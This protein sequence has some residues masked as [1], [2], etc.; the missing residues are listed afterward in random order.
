MNWWQTQLSCIYHVNAHDEHFLVRILR[1]YCCRLIQP[2]KMYINWYMM[3]YLKKDMLC[4]EH[5]F[6]D[7]LS[8]LKWSVRR[9]FFGRSGHRPLSSGHVPHGT[10]SC[11]C[12]YFVCMWNF[13]ILCTITF[14]DRVHDCTNDLFGWS[15]VRTPGIAHDQFVGVKGLSPS[16]CSTIFSWVQGSIPWPWLPV[17]GPVYPWPMSLAPTNGATGGTANKKTLIRGKKTCLYDWWP[18]LYGGVER[19]LLVTKA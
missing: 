2:V 18:L 11:I 3:W 19:Y 7:N 8:F 4:K 16:P 17:F 5:I 15:R 1:T 13:M 12:A 9:P 14:S 6:S 10:C